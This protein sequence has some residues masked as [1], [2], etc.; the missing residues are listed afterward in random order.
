M[1]QLHQIGSSWLST[2]CSERYEC[3]ACEECK[4][5]KVAKLYKYKHTCVGDEV[6]QKVDGV[7]K[8]QKCDQGNYT[9]IGHSVIQS[10]I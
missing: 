9:D 2:D 4:K 3:R 10:I 6:C 1:L 5:R 8:C 7:G